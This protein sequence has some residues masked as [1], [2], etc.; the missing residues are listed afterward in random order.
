[1]GGQNTKPLNQE[2][3][4]DDGNGP[5]SGKEWTEVSGNSTVKRVQKQV[6]A[7]TQI[8]LVNVFNTLHQHDTRFEGGHNRCG[9]EGKKGRDKN[10]T[11]P[12]RR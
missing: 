9:L 4:V 6:E 1:M 11:I 3:V 5:L 2:K 8:T 7:E 12:V 10:T